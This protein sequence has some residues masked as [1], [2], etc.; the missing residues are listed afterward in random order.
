MQDVLAGVEDLWISNKVQKPA[1]TVQTL[2]AR[3]VK[4]IKA[5]ELAIAKKTGPGTTGTGSRNAKADWHEMA[6]FI[7]AG[8]EAAAALSA[9]AKKAKAATHAKKAQQGSSMIARAL[10]QQGGV[11]RSIAAT[12]DPLL[13][14]I[15]PVRQSM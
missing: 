2:K 3:L 1:P 13:G 10:G 12:T 4:L 14:N 5:A 15:A 6:L 11:R 9:G 7:K 8:R